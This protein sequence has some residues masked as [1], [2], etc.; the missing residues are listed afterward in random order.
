MRSDDHRLHA[1]QPAGHP[2][3]A[4]REGPRAA[5]P[6]AARNRRAR[7]QSSSVLQQADAEGGAG[8][9]PHP[10]LRRPR[11]AAD[12][13]EGGL[14]R[15]SGRIP[16][17]SGLR[18]RRA[19]NALEDRLYDRDD[20]RPPG[21]HLRRRPRSLRLHVRVRAAPGADRAEEHRS[22][23][24]PVSADPVSDGRLRPRPGRSRRDRRVRDLHQHRQLAKPLSGE[25]RP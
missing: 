1:A 23:R 11:Q 8:A 19:R 12:L 2:A 18:A 9:A 14:P 20:D 5:G 10:D 17:R 22:H 24:Q 4:T 15:R 7:L 25:P 3:P 6:T 21:A 16:A 13:I